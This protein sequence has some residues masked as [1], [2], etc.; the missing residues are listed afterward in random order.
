M[1]TVAVATLMHESNSFN[2]VLT[3]LSDFRVQARDLSEWSKAH[4]E[5]AGFLAAA[6]AEN[7]TPI[8]I[9]AATATPGGPV[10]EAA[11]EQL[12]AC[13]LENLA[14]AGHFDGVYLALHGAMVAE[15]IP[16]ADNE[17]VRRIR[18]RIGPDMPLVVSHD[19]HAN[20]APET[21]THSTALL[22][23]QQNPHLD[24]R[25]RGERA[26]S[27]LARTLRREIRPTQ[28]IARPPMIWNI[29]HQNTYA[30]PLLSV[31]RQSMRLEEQPGILA[32]SVA[33]GYQYADVPY[34]GP[35]SVVVTDGD[36]EL[37]RAEAQRLSDALWDRRHN[38]RVD[39]PDPAKAVADAMRERD[40]PVALFDTGDNVLGGSAGDSTFLLE[41]LLR[42]RAVG[43]VVTISDP[44]AVREAIRAGLDG[45]F[46]MH[47]GGKRDRLH[48]DPVRIHGIV[49]SLHAGRYMEPEVRHGGSQF[50]DLGHSAVIEVDGSTA[51]LQ[52]LVLLTTLRSHP[53]SIHQI[54]SCGIYPERQKI[55]VVK[56][57][58]AP[59]AAYEPIA[60]KIVLVDSPGATAVNPARFHYNKARPGLFGLT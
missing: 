41:E 18:E 21:L 31:T 42:Q 26:A 23:Y 11:Y 53:N 60:R 22:T 24:T 54:V 29:V 46:E 15:H 39:L 20:I 48:G 56:G 38:T 35:S 25:Q 12:V 50:H 58:I 6:K 55:L 59:R 19:F 9:L 43:W 7:L 32:A 28:A 44:D 40:F 2:P 8:P 1:P 49:R 27:I 36:P 14:A 57:T 5:V 33:G 45:R 30:E 17:I 10:Q 16:Q 34:V 47:V 3:P 13:L 51:D 52:N 4:T 37:A